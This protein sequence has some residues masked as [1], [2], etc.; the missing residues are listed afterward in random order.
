[1]DILTCFMRFFYS[2][3]KA[4][5][6]SAGRCFWESGVPEN[7]LYRCLGKAVRMYLTFRTGKS[8]QQWQSR[9]SHWKPVSHIQT[10][11]IISKAS[12]CSQSPK[13]TSRWSYTIHNLHVHSSQICE[14]FMLMPTH[15]E[16]RVEGQL[17]QT[18]ILTSLTLWQRCQ[19]IQ[20]G[21][22]SVCVVLVACEEHIS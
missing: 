5:S 13:H 11:P 22:G 21:S 9:A 19:K 2:S 8:R 4:M 1:M 17:N 12:T 14:L 10:F 18:R 15:K 20:D 3:I 7:Q 16:V 6:I